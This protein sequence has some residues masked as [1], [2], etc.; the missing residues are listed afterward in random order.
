LGFCHPFWLPTSPSTLTHA[1]STNFNI[2]T[3]F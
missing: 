3:K 2:K 1:V